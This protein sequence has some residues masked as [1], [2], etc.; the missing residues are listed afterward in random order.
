[1]PESATT[2][3]LDPDL[4]QALMKLS[5]LQSVTLNGLISRALREHLANQTLLLQQ[6]FED[7][8]RELQRLGRHDPDFERAIDRVVEAEMSTGNDP[9]QGKRMFPDDM[10]TT[11]LVRG[12]LNA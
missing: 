10:P 6:E 8:I 4:K 2:I 3:R 7:T 11:A 5:A 1:M 12:L 9:A